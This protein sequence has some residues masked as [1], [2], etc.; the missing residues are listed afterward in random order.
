[1]SGRHRAERK[2]KA[3]RRRFGPGPKEDPA[4]W[5]WGA[6]ATEEEERRKEEIA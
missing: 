3:I 2:R 1:M 4:V 5:I 6:M